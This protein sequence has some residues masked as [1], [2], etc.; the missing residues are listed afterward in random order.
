[1][2]F[3][4]RAAFWLAVGVVSIASQFVL[5]AATQRI[6][7]KGLTQFTAFAHAKSPGQ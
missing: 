1:M 4:Q 5:E 3:G 2:L 6:G 7:G